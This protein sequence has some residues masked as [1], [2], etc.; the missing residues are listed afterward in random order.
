VSETPL[1]SVRGLSKV[2][3]LTSA[4]GRG[5][6]TIDAVHDVSFDVSAGGAVAIVGESGSGK[7][8][9]ARMV[10]GLEVPTS[11][12]ILSEGRELGASPTAKERRDRARHIQ[13]VFQNPYT[14]LDPRQTA[15][16]AVEEIL[17]FHG[18]MSGPA[19]RDRAIELLSSVGLGKREAASRPRQLSG[20]QCQRVAIAKALAA[21]PKL[22]V[23]DEAVSALDVSVQ[24]QILNLLADLREQTGVALLFISHN[25]AV[26]RQTCDQVLVMHRGRVVEEGPVDLVLSKP[27][28]PYT[29]Q[30]LA[31]IP[32]PGVEPAVSP[33]PRSDPETGCR[34]RAR[35]PLATERCETEPDIDPIAPGHRVRCWFAGPR[36]GA[37]D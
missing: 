34:Y 4:L 16:A 21:Q 22:L 25:L 8:T 6:R 9:T 7:T 24:A 3:V 20:G 5:R 30:L 13:I 2:F 32:R 23:L 1:L 11:G 35:C 19:R 36:D 37:T 26:V 12:Q 31:S 27:G 18:G 15:S 29:R 28:H 17:A 10:V 33:A 14:S